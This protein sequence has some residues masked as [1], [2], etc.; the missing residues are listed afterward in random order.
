MTTTNRQN[1][2]LLNQD[3]KRIYQTFKSADFKSYDFE[4]IRRVII[5]YLRENYPEDFNDYVESSEYM[6]LI[7][8]MSFIGQSLAFRI[9]LASRENFIELAETRESVLRLARLLSYQPKRNV[10]ASGLLKF[11][12]ITTNENIIDSTGKNLAG[13]VI[14]WNDPTNP[15]WFE[16][17]V[18]ILNSAMIDNVEFGKSQGSA[19]IH[20]IQSEQYR[21]RSRFGDVPLFSFDKAVANRRIPF[22]LV[23][24]TF[25]DAQDFYEEPPVVNNQ[26]GF[27]YRNDGKGNSS[28]NTGFFIMLKQGK[29]ELTEFSI[30]VPTTNEIVSVDRENIN[31]SDVWLFSLDQLNRQTEMWAKVPSLIGNNIIYNS[32]S[33]RVRNIY[34]VVTREDDKIDLVFA[35]GVYGNLPRGRFRLY[36]RISNGLN[37]IINP[38]EMRGINITVPY[39]SKTGNLAE[40]SISLSLKQSIT[41][42]SSAEDID[43]IRTR[44]P[45]IYYTQNRMVTGEDYNLAPLSSSQ[46]IIKVKAINRTSSG[47]SRNYDIIDASGKYS[48]VNVFADDGYLFKEQVDESLTLNYNNR[49]DVINYIRQYIE[50]IITSHEV[51]NFYL[52]KFDQI[53]FSD[54][55]LS[56]ESITTDVNLNTG[57][58]LD[59]YSSAQK[60]GVYT[61]TP[62]KYIAPS[63]LVKFVPPEGYAFKS[64]QLVTANSAD[65]DQKDRIWCKVVKVVGD[66]TTKLKNGTGPIVFN[67]IVP[68]GAIAVSILPRF[69][70]NL[71]VE[72]ENE[73]VNQVMSGLDFGLRYDY[74]TSNWRI[75]TTSNLNTVDTFSLS[76]SGSVANL[77]LD[78][79][80]IISFTKEVT[81]YSITVRK[82]KYVFG[83]L[84]QNRFF[85]DDSQRIYDS[86]TGKVIQDSVKILGINTDST[87]I[88]PLQQDVEFRVSSSIKFEDGY[89]STKEIAIAF[90]DTDQDGVIDNP[91]S[92]VQVVGKDQDLNYIFFKKEVDQDGNYVYGYVDQPRGTIAVSQSQLTADITQFKDQQL[93]YFYSELEDRV[94]KVDRQSGTYELQPDYKA[95]VGRVGLKFQYTHSANAD[96]RIDPSVSNIVDMFL[97]TKSYDIAYRNYIGG[98]GEKPVPPTSDQLKTMYGQTLDS[99]KTMSDEIV[100]YPASYKILFGSQAD[101]RLQAQ[102]LVVKNPTK[103]VND[104]E[105]K[106]KVVSAI[107]SFFDVKNW[108][109]GDRFYIS[110]LVTF[111]INEVSP[112]ISNIV[113]VPRQADLVFG[114]LFEIQSNPDEI[115]ISSATVNDIKIVP[116]ISASELRVPA[117]VFVNTTN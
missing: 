69:V 114:S 12:T 74:V 43:S 61:T 93:V 38:A 56:W 7:D 77:N 109:F 107:N 13:Q 31:D 111:I 68:T 44:A 73:I 14:I 63:C 110:E 33:S 112:D 35:D 117:S 115:F 10:A 4:N 24:T 9:D 49:L 60:T 18:L 88:K 17:F 106:V 28:P 80:W 19:V 57:R 53:L 79:S 45:A 84:T 62:L 30:D 42:A 78:S 103:S 89:Q 59:Q 64:G 27:V 47:I 29:L 108:D 90:A 67:E 95:V 54:L 11:D 40:V 1:N 37:Y 82:M 91:D 66:G 104:N 5:A 8:A 46:D 52:T 39:V 102:F 6:A 21:F 70:T 32:L 98:K 65:P 113:I 97:L 22:E 96:R 23:S 34:N 105:V 26:L 87:K 20:G 72:M 75:I 25:K 55:G 101:P 15:N 99:I 51:F 92:F 36:H 41:N 94:M 16:Q 116:Y 2:L 58:F 48:S 76:N 85:Y 86:R 81:N 100:Y 71:S 83:S 50:P 3:W